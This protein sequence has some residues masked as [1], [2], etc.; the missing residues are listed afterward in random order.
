[1]LIFLYLQNPYKNSIAKADLNHIMISEGIAIYL[2]NTPEVLMKRVAKIKLDRF[3]NN[4][5]PFL[6]KN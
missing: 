5:F 4:Y 1:M 3:L 6:L 2:P